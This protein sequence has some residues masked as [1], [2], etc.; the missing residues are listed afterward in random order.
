MIISG[1]LGAGKTTFLNHILRNK[2]GLR[3]AVIVNDMASLNVDAELVSEAIKRQTSEN[4]EETEVVE[5]TNG[6][7]CCTLRDDLGRQIAELTVNARGKGVHR[8]LDYI[9][10]ES[11]GISEPLPVAQIFL[12]PLQFRQEDS[13][14]TAHDNEHSHSHGSVNTHHGAHAS[15]K[16]LNDIAFIDAMVSVVDA[17]NFWK[18]FASGDRLLDRHMET[19]PTDTRSIVDLLTVQV[20]YANIV[21]INKCDLVPAAKVDE[22]EAFL[23]RLNPSAKCVRATFSNV[24]LATVLHTGLFNFDDV[25]HAPGWLQDLVGDHESETDAFGFTSFVFR[26]RRPFLAQKFHNLVSG[27]DRPG[28][29]NNT[30]VRSAHVFRGV[31]RSKGSF[32]I[33]EEP[34]TKWMW[35]SSF[36]SRSIRRGD[37]GIANAAQ[38]QPGFLSEIVFIGIKMNEDLIRAALKSA[39]ATDSDLQAYEQLQKPLP[40]PWMQQKKG[41]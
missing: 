39:E 23:L 6:C 30:S 16:T 32:S 17:T 38:K 28:A 37:I 19:T 36:S 25:A 13:H 11:T 5:L 7:I 33:A 24:A 12:L 34:S 14:D 35:S 3:V 21:V 15:A 27:V 10:V 22:L 26:S 41:K 9:L 29:P 2:D 31:L 18:D 20:E 1:F 4:C 8:R 40:H